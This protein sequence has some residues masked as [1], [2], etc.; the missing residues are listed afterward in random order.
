MSKVAAKLPQVLLVGSVTD[1][2][3]LEWAVR[4]AQSKFWVDRLE[5]TIEAHTLP[6]T[7]VRERCDIP[8]VSSLTTYLCRD[9]VAI[10]EVLRAAGIPVA[11][12]ATEEFIEGYEGIYDTLTVQGDVHHEFVG[13]YYPSVFDVMPRAGS[14]RN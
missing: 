14:R 8:G 9:K 7:H 13:H 1:E 10:K 5:A 6:A 11:A 4:D 3:A 12:A 2:G